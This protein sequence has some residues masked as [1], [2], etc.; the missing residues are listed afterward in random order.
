VEG[1]G[2]GLAECIEGGG[3]AGLG[4]VVVEGAEDD[5]VGRDLCCGEEFGGAV[6][7]CGEVGLSGHFE[8]EEAAGQGIFAGGEGAVVAEEQVRNIVPTEGQVFAI[9]RH[10]G[11]VS[12]NLP[13]IMYF[14]QVFY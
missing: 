12:I 1:L 11:K 10:K 14:F 6:G 8:S 4:L 7:P 5:R 3:E 9:V 13:G 2:E